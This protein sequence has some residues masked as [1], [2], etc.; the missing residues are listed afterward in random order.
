[1]D[2]HL[3]SVTKRSPVKLI[4]GEEIYIEVSYE[5]NIRTLAHFVIPYTVKVSYVH[6]LNKNLTS[7][8]SWNS[9][10]ITDSEGYILKQ[11]MEISVSILSRNKILT[12]FINIFSL[13]INGF[14]EIIINHRLPDWPNS[15][16]VYLS[17]MRK[18]DSFHN[19]YNV[20]SINIS[21]VE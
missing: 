20:K 10:S 18:V 14:Y 2:I 3:H 8:I 6:L 7:D 11:G 9:S 17:A 19:G 21:I 12:F 16:L 5:H 13:I 4:L 15:K 1:M